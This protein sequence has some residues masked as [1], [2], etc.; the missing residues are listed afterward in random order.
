MA[1]ALQSASM[2]PPLLFTPLLRMLEA[3][4]PVR[5]RQKLPVRNCTRLWFLVTEQ[6]PTWTPEIL[7]QNPGKLVRKTTLT[8]A[9]F[10]FG[11]TENNLKLRMHQTP[12]AVTAR[13]LD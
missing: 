7:L 13:K 8:S 10:C 11:F 9:S 3:H 6:S 12:H 4:L 5:Q 2:L 1:G